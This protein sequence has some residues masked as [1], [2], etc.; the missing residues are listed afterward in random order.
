MHY[1][2]IHLPFLMKKS[3]YLA[4][5]NSNSLAAGIWWLD[6]LFPGQGMRQLA[7]CLEHGQ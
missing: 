3:L 4:T 5:P 2:S 6:S 1:L 7:Y